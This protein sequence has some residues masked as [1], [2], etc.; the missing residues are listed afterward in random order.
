MAALWLKPFAPKKIEAAFDSAH[1]LWQGAPRFADL[2]GF[3]GPVPR[4]QDERTEAAH[5]E[6]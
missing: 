2:G 1:A 4:Q 5:G 3:S 6:A